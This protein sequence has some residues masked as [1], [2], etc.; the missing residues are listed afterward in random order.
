LRLCSGWRLRGLFGPWLRIQPGRLV[1]SLQGAHFSRTHR[2]DRANLVVVRDLPAR[3]P[4]I[5]NELSHLDDLLL[6]A[7]ILV[8]DETAYLGAVLLGLSLT[9]VDWFVE[10]DLQFL[11]R[12]A[13]VFLVRLDAAVKDRQP[14]AGDH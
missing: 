4:S 2:I 5:L 10:V 11:T 6:D 12:H 1:A 14:A 7:C 13:G 9:K 8:A 3:Q